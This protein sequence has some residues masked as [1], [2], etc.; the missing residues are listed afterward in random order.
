MA[1]GM[2]VVGER[3]GSREWLQCRPTLEDGPPWQRLCIWVPPTEENQG[4][5]GGQ[6]QSHEVK[7]AG[8]FLKTG[9]GPPPQRDWAGDCLV[10]KARSQGL[11][12]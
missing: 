8:S 4:W 1:E 9:S 12:R 11:Q 6:A 2:S 5:G 10:D 3:E 7:E